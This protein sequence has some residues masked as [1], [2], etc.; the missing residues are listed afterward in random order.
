M[1][2]PQWKGQVL[3]FCCKHHTELLMILVVRKLGGHYSLEFDNFFSN[4]IFK[5][6]YQAVGFH[7]TLIIP[8]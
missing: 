7:K 1:L 5:F 2:K 3:P 8:P 6:T 4:C